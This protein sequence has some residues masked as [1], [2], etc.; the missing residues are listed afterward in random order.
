MLS[1]QTGIDFINEGLTNDINTIIKN[2]FKKNEN[3][4]VKLPNN[5]LRNLNHYVFNKE[6]YSYVFLKFNSKKKFKYV[7]D[8]LLSFK[9]HT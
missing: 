2:G 7:K 1:A 4:I 6:N 8:I 5:S 9:D 3:S